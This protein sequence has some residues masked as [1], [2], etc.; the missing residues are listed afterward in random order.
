MVCMPTI[1]LC[2]S[3]QSQLYLF[4]S[5][6]SLQPH[7]FN[8]HL[9]IF[10][11]CYMKSFIL[12]FVSSTGHLNDLFTYVIPFFYNWSSCVSLTYFTITWILFICIFL[13][14]TSKD[15]LPAPYSAGRGFNSGSHLHSYFFDMDGLLNEDNTTQSY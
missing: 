4:Y 6:A 10:V 7:W 13:L 15:W 8:R 5:F 14:L 12:T 2:R 11:D 3:L 9:F 1:V